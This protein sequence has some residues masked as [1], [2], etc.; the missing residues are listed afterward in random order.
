[1]D[2][3]SNAEEE[4]WKGLTSVRRRR[5]EGQALIEFALVAP[6]LMLIIFGI[7]DLAL[8]LNYQNDNTNLANVAARYATVIGSASSAP[9][10]NGSATTDVYTFIQCEAKSDSAALGNGV[11]VC[12]TDET[13]SGSYAVGDAVKITVEYPFQFMSL[14]T[15]MSVNIES[16][17]TMM[18]EAS[19]SSSTS[20]T[21]LSNTDSDSSDPA[22]NNVGNKYQK[23]STIT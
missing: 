7:V 4:L 12:V 1:M 10:C 16:S 18:M 2:D 17:S 6:V 11:G 8:G 19:A 14:V 20:G 9:V 22:V 13:S 21:W 23:C 15:S 3:Y 5:E